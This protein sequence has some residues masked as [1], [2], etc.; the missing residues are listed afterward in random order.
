MTPIEPAGFVTAVSDAIGKL[1]GRPALALLGMALIFFLLPAPRLAAIGIDQSN[2]TWRAV[3][4]HLRVGRFF[5]RSC[6]RFP[7][8]S[9]SHL[10]LGVRRQRQIPEAVSI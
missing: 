9:S 8:A 1:F 3:A 2:S 4:A 6:P 7:V 10:P 5:L